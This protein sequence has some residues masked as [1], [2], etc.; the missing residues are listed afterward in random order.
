M[1]I[2][3]LIKEY[4]EL[5]DMLGI[6]WAIGDNRYYDIMIALDDIDAIARNLSELL[7]GC[8]DYGGCS[9][10]E[11]IEYSDICRPLEPD[12]VV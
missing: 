3:E 5:E 10:I 4:R 12:W 6:L 1:V 9:I 7:R 8:V 2:S 11:I